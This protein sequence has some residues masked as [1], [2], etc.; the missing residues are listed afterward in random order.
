MRRIPPYIDCILHYLMETCGQVA[1]S[2]WRPARSGVSRWAQA[3]RSGGQH[4]TPSM[5]GASRSEGVGLHQPP[6]GSTRF[7]N[8]PAK[9]M[10][11]CGQITCTARTRGTIRGATCNPLLGGGNPT[12]G[13]IRRTL[14]FGGV[15]K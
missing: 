15:R 1:C 12:Q 9:L 5:E 6:P 14:D 7:L 13:S 8:A 3:A 11:T 10:E 2:V 4:A